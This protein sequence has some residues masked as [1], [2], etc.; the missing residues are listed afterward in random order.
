MPYSSGGSQISYVIRNLETL[1]T[2]L[3][4]L[5]FPAV[6]CSDS[7][8]AWQSLLC[9]CSALPCLRVMYFLQLGRSMGPT[10]LQFLLDLLKHLL[11]HSEQLDAQNQQKL[12]AARAESDLFLDMESVAS[13]ELATDKVLP[14][15]FSLFSFSYKDADAGYF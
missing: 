13:L 1:L 12:E 15:P 10:L 8:G 11:I 14:S 2:S 3:T 7:T 6:S 4:S 9:G 5:A